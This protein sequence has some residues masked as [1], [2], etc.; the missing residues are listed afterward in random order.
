MLVTVTFIV[1]P[2]NCNC[3]TLGLNMAKKSKYG[4]STVVIRVPKSLVPRIR[5]M[6]EKLEVLETNASLV[7]PAMKPVCDLMASAFRDQMLSI[8]SIFENSDTNTPEQ[9]SELAEMRKTFENKSF[10]GE[11]SAGVLASYKESEDNAKNKNKN[12]N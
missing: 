6:M 9:K 8:V 12:K 5:K 3:Y 2:L 4:E 10:L 11:F 7:A 1:L